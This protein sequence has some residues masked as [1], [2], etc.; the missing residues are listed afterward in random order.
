M[1]TLIEEIDLDFY[2]DF[3]YTDKRGRKFMY[4]ETKTSIYDTLEV[5]LLFWVNLTKIL[6]YIVY[7][8]N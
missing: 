6:E 3:I 7:Q 8:R 2:E 1:V 4:A 5:S